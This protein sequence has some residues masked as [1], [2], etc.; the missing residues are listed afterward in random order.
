[1]IESFLSSL[2]QFQKKETPLPKIII[3]YGPTA[4]G[5][6]ALSIELAQYL[7]TEIISTDSR[8]IYRDMDIWTGKITEQEMQWI[9]HHMLDII[10]P[11]QIFSM[12]EFGKKSLTF[13]ENIIQKWKI[14]ILC[15]G[16]GLYID[17]VLYEMAIPD[18]EPDWKYREELEKIT[19]AI[20]CVDLR[21]FEKQGNQKE[22]PK[23]QRL[24]DLNHFLLLHIMMKI[25]K[26]SIRI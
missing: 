18:S 6:T 8:Q 13:I 14:P 21:Y 5:K 3:V 4:C 7:D 9:P 12:A 11:T 22:N 20:L 23:I 25:E 17:S 2:N 15:G 24:S 10:Y 19:F 26:I 1:M 16:T